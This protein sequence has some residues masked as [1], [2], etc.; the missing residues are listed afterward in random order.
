MFRSIVVRGLLDFG[1]HECATIPGFSLKKQQGRIGPSCASRFVQNSAGLI[2]VSALAT[3]LHRI[4]EASPYTR[5]ARLGAFLAPWPVA[6]SE[7]N[8]EKT[9]LVVMCQSG[10]VFFRRQVKN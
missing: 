1:T 8:F 4:D 9:L 6:V 5:I 10:V 3:F 2:F 7:G